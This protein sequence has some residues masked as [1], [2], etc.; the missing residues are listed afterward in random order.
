MTELLKSFENSANV[1][2]ACLDE[3][4]DDLSLISFDETNDQSFRIRVIINRLEN[5]IFDREM[6]V[7]L[8]RGQNRWN[9]Q[10]KISVLSIKHYLYQAGW[11]LVHYNREHSKRDCEIAFN[12]IINKIQEADPKT[13]KINTLWDLCKWDLCKSELNSDKSNL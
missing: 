13:V 4:F 9:E 8:D 10:K 7:Y 3:F 5:Y 1:I 11:D 2:N 12:R 6:A